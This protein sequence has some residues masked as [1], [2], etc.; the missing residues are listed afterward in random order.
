[1][2]DI[3]ERRYYDGTYLSHNPDWDRSDSP[4]K[5]DLVRTILNEFRITPDSICEIG[6]GA[7][8]ILAHLKKSFPNAALT[9]FDISPDVARFWKQHE[10]DGIQFRCGDFLELDH[11]NYDCI[12]VLD[13]LEHLANPF[14]FLDGIKEAGTYF[15][16]HFP[17]DLS[18]AGVL[19]EKRLLQ[20]RLDVGH[21]HYFTKG[22]ALTLLRESGYEIMHWRYTHASLSGPSRKLKTR[23][24]SIPRRLAYS[25]SRDLAVRLLGGETLMV[26]ARMA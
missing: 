1:M 4:W 9:G 18:A 10:E 2:R 16:F 26:L 6:C 11:Q 7:G 24:A 15:V 14:A 17:L 13:V 3:V 23:L 21:L 12:L 25:L 20:T 19:R 5:A 22:L 8:A